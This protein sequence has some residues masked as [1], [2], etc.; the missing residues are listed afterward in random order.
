[1]RK[2]KKRKWKREREKVSK[3]ETKFQNKN[4]NEIKKNHSCDTKGQWKN[5]KEKR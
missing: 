3:K 5:E 4:V 1:M 2:V